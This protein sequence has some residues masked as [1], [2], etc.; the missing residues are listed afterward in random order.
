MR[1]ALLSVILTFGGLG[2]FLLAWKTKP[3]LCDSFYL[4]G[5]L[6]SAIAVNCWIETFSDSY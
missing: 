3:Q 5:F 4:S 6:V 1:L 2:F